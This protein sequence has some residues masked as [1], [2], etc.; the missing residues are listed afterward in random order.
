MKRLGHAHEANSHRVQ[1]YIAGRGRRV[2][3]IPETEEEPTLPALTGHAARPIDMARDPP[4][5]WFDPGCEQQP[6]H[7][8]SHARR[9]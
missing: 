1:F 7:A 9:S 6:S 4:V 5:H 2:P 8:A 3:I